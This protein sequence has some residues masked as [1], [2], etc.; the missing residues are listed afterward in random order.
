MCL[1]TRDLP[2]DTRI[3]NA[4]LEVADEPDERNANAQA[5][6]PHLDQVQAALALAHERRGVADP[7]P[8]SSCVTPAPV[9]ASR[10]SRKKTAYSSEKVGSSKLCLPFLSVAGKHIVHLGIV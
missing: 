10:S 8:S 2:D 6:R 1:G 5:E 4:V 3:L 9:L 7:R